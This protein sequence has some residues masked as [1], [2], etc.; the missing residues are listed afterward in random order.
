MSEPPAP[1]SPREGPQADFSRSLRT[2]RPL[3]LWFLGVALLGC[4]AGLALAI[5]G[6]PEPAGEISGNPGPVRVDPLNSPACRGPEE[7]PRET[8][9]AGNFPRS[10]P[11]AGFLELPAGPDSRRAETTTSEAALLLPGWGEAGAG[12]NLALG[13]QSFPPEG[14]VPGGQPLG[15]PLFPHLCFPVAWPFSFSN[16]FGEPRENSR[17]HL[18][19][20][21]FAEEGTEVYAVT[22][23]TIARL[24]CLEKGGLSL[25]LAGQDGRGYVYM[26][27]QRFA[28]GLHPGRQVQKGELLGAVGRT[29]TV[30]SAPHLH[31]QVHGA[32]DFR[33]ETA[34]NPFALLVALAD[35]RGVRETQ[36]SR[37]QKP[38][39]AEIDLG[40]PSRGARPVV[41]LVEAKTLRLRPLGLDWRIPEPTWKIPPATVRLPP[42]QRKSPEPA[43]R[44]SSLPSPSSPPHRRIK[45]IE[46]SSPAED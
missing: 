42:P 19:I 13:D 15:N 16:S 21:I 11:P 4:L 25:Y 46:P 33:R 40:R 5:L 26:H 37:H 27:L 2:P 22:A 17:P 18:G 45:V 31:F 24:A 29:G 43:T 9:A 32:P 7:S 8:A 38:Q 44:M 36:P 28:P 23:G 3:P 20:D 1:A 12:R 6:M 14:P 30:N 35:H 10:A 39:K 34:L 41:F